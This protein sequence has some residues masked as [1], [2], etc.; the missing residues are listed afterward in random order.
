MRR[1][2]Q[3]LRLFL[4]TVYKPIMVCF[5]ILASNIAFAQCPPNI[6]FELGDFTGWQ[7]WT[8][9]TEVIAGKNVITW[10]ATSPGPPVVG[11]HTMLS[12]N[13]GNGRDP[14]GLFPQNCPNGSGNSIKLGNASGGHQAEGVSYTFTI[15]AGQNKFN[16]I[17]NYAVV[18]Q[19]P[20][21]LED[22]QPRLKINI[23][24][25]TDGTEISCSSFPFI[26]TSGLPGF[27]LSPA[28]T[29]GT[30]VW[31]KNWS[32]NSV[33]LD[34]NAG[35]TIRLFFT[36]ADCIFTAHFGYAYV[37]VNTQCGSSF[38]GATF[39]PDDTLVNVVAPFGYESYKWFSLTNPNLG[40][41]QT[42]TLNPPP[43]SGD[44]VFVELTPYNGYGCLDTLTAN[45]WDTLTVNANAGADK[46]TCDNNPVR[47]GVPP[48]PGLV[49][50]WSPA[51]GLSNPNISNPLAS[52]LVTTPYTLIVTNSGGG[53]ATP[54]VVNVNVDVLSDSIE[55]IGAAS[56]CIGSGQSAA[57][58]V[59][60]A[61]SI[62]WYKDNVAIPGTNQT[63]LNISQT[64]IYYAML[65]SS[66]GC[67]RTTA[68]KQINIYE[69]PIA[70]FDADAAAK[71]F[72]GHQFI[73]TNRSSI[74]A[75]ALQYAWSM[76]DG[77]VATT[78]NVMHSYA[79]DSNY[80]VKLLVTAPGGCVDSAKFN[81]VV[82]PSPYASFAIDSTKD[83]FK[84][85]AFIF[86]NESKA[87]SGS[88]MYNWDLGDVTLPTTKDVT[89]SYSQ[90]GTY[91]IKLSATANGG[92][93]DDSSFA[94][95]VYPSPQASFKINN[96]TQCFPGHQFTF[97]NSS[98]IAY[99]TMQYT[100]ALGDGTFNTIDTVQY[101]YAKAGN[102]TVKLLVSALGGCKDSFSLP[103]IVHPT[104]SA[105]FTAQPVCVNLRVPVYN[106]TFNNTSSTVNYFWDFDNGHL[107]NNPVP[108]YQY[109]T[110]GIY[111]LKLTVSTAQCPASLHSKTINLVIDAPAKPIRYPDEDAAFNFPE[112]LQAR[113]IGNSVTWMPAVNLSNRFSYNPT[114]T[115]LIPQ[116]YTIL[117]KTATGCLTVDTQYVKTNKKIKIY[118]PTAFTP[119]GNGT[120]D[121]LR[122]VLIG[123]TKVNYFR[124]YNRWGKLLFSMNS[125]QPGWDGRIENAPAGIQTVVW[126]IEAVDV[127][128]KVHSQQGSTVL[129]R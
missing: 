29:T 103:V 99:N 118:V 128:G 34:G 125:D 81:V 120:N 37:D 82:N 111:K 21:H 91:L 11:R 51:T 22:E 92:C 45:L 121:R 26:A 38:V 24:N 127:D 13:P 48:L 74:S 43:L 126:M 30:P 62:Q 27:Y 63:Q 129:Y 86:T 123:F 73:F 102:Y 20:G 95:I 55:L 96:D 6:D 101:S 23:E 83:C 66:A 71:C 85:N 44:S 52:P 100:W 31:C 19:D 109:P 17:Y 58:K 80:T 105:D 114:F 46:E 87:S 7:C 72:A 110:A 25:V 1:L 3:N 14:F 115:G 4:S 39:C 12:S 98:T 2:Y 60:A 64:G 35:K 15:P 108:V 54:D 88:L 47:I 50:K 8:G 116:E 113:P 117:L 42:L 41:Q 69:T 49:Y 77:T 32:A 94:V 33:N 70:G 89:H 61:D 104:P 53:C 59:L 106:R 112:P 68:V 78:R 56:Y 67:S 36:T 84:N 65:F 90:P 124:I 9:N 75:G 10:D 16:L 76:G 107:D 119:D 40:T 18:F 28:N 79:K 122:P 93:T 97:S 57:L 5:F